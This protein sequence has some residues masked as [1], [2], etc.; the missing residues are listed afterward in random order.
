[1]R[2][3][4]VGRDVKDA[5]KKSSRGRKAAE[6]GE[7]QKKQKVKEDERKVSPKNDLPDKTEPIRRPKGTATQT[8]K[9][10]IAL[11]KNNDNNIKTEI[12]ELGK[13]K[14]TAGRT[15]PAGKVTAE[16]SL[17]PAQAPP[18]AN[19]P[20][21]A[22]GAKAGCSKSALAEVNILPAVGAAK[23]PDKALPKDRA[24]QKT[25]PRCEAVRNSPAQE[26]SDDAAWEEMGP[27]LADLLAEEAKSAV[28]ANQAEVFRSRCEKGPFAAVVKGRFLSG[29]RLRTNK[30]KDLALR[31]LAPSTVKA[32]VRMLRY[33]QR[34]PERYQQLNLDRAMEQYL[35]DS[36][37]ERRWLPTTMVVKMATAHGALR[38]LPLYAEGELPVLMRESVTWMSAMKAAAKM[39]KQ[40]PPKQPTAA[41]WAEVEEAIKRETST[42]VRMALLLT[43]LTCGRGG[44]VLLLNPSHVE[45]EERETK[46]GKIS[47]MAVSFWKGKTVKT[48]GS[49]TV[50]TQP[51]PVFLL[52]EWKKYHKSVE[53]QRYLFQGVKGAQIKIALR[54]ANPKL[55]QRSLRR[56][57]IQALA[58]TGLKDEELLHYS[59]HTNVTMLRRYLNFGKVSGEG[60]RL[61]SQAMALVQ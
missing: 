39:A 3:G 35:L 15:Q 41:K 37:A 53:A 24:S 26:V 57:A 22:V 30:V 11:L 48:R 54:R 42:A 56:G 8:A 10:F 43:W 47:V 16:E 19:V 36:K 38:L 31:A 45:I 44:D 7:E 27:M 1:M 60:T 2:P 51:P 40:H 13:P 33:L 59:G 18:K 29:L 25:P 46:A 61:A 55:E 4:E 5:A 28:N 52:D 14:T 6:R 9:E 58:A 21:V 23:Q 12:K 17:Q 49:Y 50:F 20:T 34:I 32:H